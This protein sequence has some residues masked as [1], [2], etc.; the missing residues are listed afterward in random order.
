MKIALASDHAGFHLKEALLAHLKTLGHTTADL[1]TDSPDRPVDYPDFA[2]KAGA[3]VLSG[4]AERAIVVCGS[5]VGAC[6]AANKLRGIRAGLCH[7]NYSAHQAVE[8][9]DINILCLGARIVG[10]ALA[11]EIAAT[12]AA[13]EF[14]QA[15]RHKKRLAKIAEL[16]KENK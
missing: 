7:D 2:A 12:F 3:A 13:A 10:T 16:E 14:S 4:A 9:D 15:E 8:H 6:V 5:G 1:G 11:F